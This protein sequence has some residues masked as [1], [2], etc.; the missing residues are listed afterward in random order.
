MLVHPFDATTIDS[1]YRIWLWAGHALPAV[2]GTYAWTLTHRV[3]GRRLRS[4]RCWQVA[5]CAA[6]SWAGCAFCCRWSTTASTAFWPMRWA[7]VSCFGRGVC[8]AHFQN[9]AI[10]QPWGTFF[11]RISRAEVYR[12]VCSYVCQRGPGKTIQTISLLATLAERKGVTGPHM[13]LAPKACI[14]HC[15]FLIFSSGR[16]GL[17]AYALPGVLGCHRSA[18][19][20]CRQKRRRRRL[21]VGYCCHGQV[22]HHGYS[23]MLWQAALRKTLSVARPMS[24]PRGMALHRCCLCVVAGSAEQLGQ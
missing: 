9:H 19:K 1:H 15:P 24:L 12:L 3:G 14:C 6:T 13:I 8:L 16:I 11:P 20:Y 10:Y 7:S 23:H 21:K 17:E 4:Q 18:A 22:F 5:R 2:P